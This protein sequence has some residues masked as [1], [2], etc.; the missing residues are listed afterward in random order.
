MCLMYCRAWK[1]HLRNI[2]VNSSGCDVGCCIGSTFQQADMSANNF[3]STFDSF[4]PTKRQDAFC[5]FRRDWKIIRSS[6]L[7]RGDCK[8]KTAKSANRRQKSELNDNGYKRCWKRSCN[9]LASNNNWIM[10]TTMTT[11]TIKRT[12]TTKTIRRT[13]TLWVKNELLFIQESYRTLVHKS[14]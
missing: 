1:H 10:K 3:T 12:T 7:W 8:T 9:V 14:M 2:K 4:W 11:K 6:P 5:A 13:M